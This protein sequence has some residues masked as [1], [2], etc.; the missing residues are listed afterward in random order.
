MNDS[1]GEIVSLKNVLQI[2]SDD[3]GLRARVNLAICNFLEGDFTE[4]EKHLLVATKIQE[5]TSAESKNER[6][7]W[8]YLSNILKWHKNKYLKRRFLWQ[9]LGVI[10][11]N[12]L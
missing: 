8:R 9:F 11:M 7:Y 1:E 2:D 5:K 6:V 4:S 3:Y 10:N 12:M